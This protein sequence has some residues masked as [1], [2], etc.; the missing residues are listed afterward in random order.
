MSEQ[1]VQDR[2][3]RVFISSTF[4]D[5]HA[6]RDHLVKVV[7]PQLRRLCE[8]R[9]VTWG[10]VDLRWG[11]T[12]EAA[13]EGKVLPICLEEI[14]R[15]RP[16]FIGLLGER[17]G[18]VPESIPQELLGKEAWLQEQL[19]EH[20]SVTELEILHGVLRNPAMAGHAFFYFRDPAWLAHLPAGAR[21]ED[22]ISEDAT[23]A[24][25]LREL[26]RQIRTS[27]LP[28]REDYPS[29]AALGDLVLADLTAVINR[30]WPEGSQ[31]DPLDREALDHAAYARS[32]ER[33]YIGRPEYFARLDA[34]AAGGGDQ[35]LVVLGESGSGKS[36]LL[37]NWA[38][39]YRRAHPDAFVLEH[40]IGA[41]PGSADWAALL[42]RIMGEF[43]RK[44]GLQQ[45]IPDKPDALRSAC[46]NWLHMAA[47]KG[48]IVLLLDALNQLEDREGAQELLW[49]PPVMPGNVRLIVSTLPGKP[50]DE[51][52]KRGWPVLR[53]EPLSTD[54][55]HEL[56]RQF[57]GQYSRQLS[58][59]RIDRI[60]AAPQSDN[61][62]Y[63]RVLLDELRLF[64]IHE[65]LD[66]RIGHYL[67]AESPYELYGK[68]IAR[69]EADYGGGSDLVGDSVSLLWAARHGLSEGELLDA[70]GQDGQPL[71]RAVWSP[72]FLAMADALISRNGLLTFA[73][74]FLRMAAR[75][76]C[77]PTEAHQRK[78][79][80]RLAD[81]FQR[82]PSGSRR[83]DE[84]PWQLAKARAW[85]RL[86][87]LLADRAFL[88]EAWDRNQFEVKVYWTEM[89][90]DSALRM[91]ETYGGLIEHPDQEDDKDHLW[92]VSAML[93][94]TG[95]P[96][97]ALGLRGSLVD[98]FRA[99]GD[100]ANLGVCLGN[101]A[102]ILYARGD[103]DGAIALFKDV[104]RICR[105]LGNLD[106][107]QACLGNQAGILYARGDLDRAM[108]LHKEQERICHQLGNLD[109]LQA[110]LGN[111]ANIL[112]TR[113]DLDGAM[114][115]HKEEERI[116]RQLGNLDGLSRTLGN[117]AVILY[118][119]G[120]L[121]GAMALH[122]E[123]ERIC[124]QLGNLHGLQACLGNQAVILKD[125]GDLDGAMA[126]DKKK[127]RTCR[128]LG[129]L[130]GLQAC[131]GN[132]AVILYARGDLDG[133]M[134]LLKEKERIC[135][136]LGN[137]DGLQHT[138]GNQALILKDRGDLNGAMALWKEQER[139]CRQ[140]GNPDG[141]QRTLGNQAVIL[142]DCGDLDGAMALNKEKER[143]C[144]Q[145][146]DTEGLA[147]S[148]ANQS[149]V[150]QQQG[151]AGAGL[152]LVEEAHRLAT[153][154]G[155]AALARQIE[156]ILNYVRR[157]AASN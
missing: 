104:E 34:H 70:L 47:A 132:Q 40:Y 80:K 154:H 74:D 9:G 112:Y 94:D 10:E 48:R 25:K 141:L 28:V 17:Y 22:Y 88:A 126:L 55:R 18:W 121:D 44:L 19:R 87:D 157:A 62:L 58:P 151:Q 39:G 1:C 52:G 23:S 86:R 15:C 140:L 35:P 56:V 6:E 92:R 144:R 111:Q 78:A 51:V 100:T 30:R 7:F 3:I 14:N 108:A 26:K 71:P 5:M 83:T 156:P 95:H 41:T 21:R 4:R 105:Q 136:Q 16:Y 90:A 13:A 147:T 117:Q 96:E 54:E 53:V 128:Q 76:A 12:D 61:P 73:H 142:K 124:R 109:G 155:Y 118:A 145:L 60:A 97:E 63:L 146:G 106:G 127:E 110:C 29:P 79:H 138:L 64:G 143:I 33:V 152:P 65:K 77:V 133:A 134:A 135:R 36:A 24:D 27:G 72:L 67:Q 114:A 91:T 113:G 120:D 85:P 69:W 89:E 107:L 68:V 20:K 101:Q 103:L 45:D 11:V 81:Y 50:L 38:A 115:L 99:T 32:R 84:L 43:K 116:C 122:K 149:L 98:H 49:L 31:P 102:N 148:L 66:E 131:L 2:Q 137:P 37:A 8:S 129:N 123:E 150:L 82:Q 119:R 59:A 139:I 57:L 46:P 130:H 75:D 153:A 42:R 125:R 93:A